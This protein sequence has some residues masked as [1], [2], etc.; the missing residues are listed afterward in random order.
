MTAA[1]G[2]APLFAGTFHMLTEA[3]LAEAMPLCQEVSQA[4]RRDGDLRTPITPEQGEAIV[5]ELRKQ[6]L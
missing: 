6:G 4:G 3:E 5:R 2:F 1:S